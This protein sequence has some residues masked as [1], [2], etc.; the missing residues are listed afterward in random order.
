MERGEKKHTGIVTSH[1]LL[2]YEASVKLSCGRVRLLGQKVLSGQ[3]EWLLAP[4]TGSILVQTRQSLTR[5]CHG[6]LSLYLAS[7]SPSPSPAPTFQISLPELSR[8]PKIAPPP[9]F[10][11]SAI[12]SL[13]ETAE[14][15]GCILKHKK[16]GKEEEKKK[17]RRGWKTAWG[18]CL[19]WKSFSLNSFG[20][21]VSSQ[22]ASYNENHP[23]LLIHACPLR[24]TQTP[25]VPTETTTPR[26]IRPSRN[27][28][29]QVTA[30]GSRLGR[31]R[32]F[33][34]KGN[35]GLGWIP[36]EKSASIVGGG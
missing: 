9:R 7:W 4:L 14:I 12:T 17:K 25:L 30:A 6:E 32:T 11:H 18:K 2:R 23:T 29:L 34:C 13:S 33:S 1:T 31:R 22:T 5:V 26:Q 3:G 10:S 19:V 8:L 27:E 35:R 28:R 24:K 16:K 36:W 20:K 15:F 21:A